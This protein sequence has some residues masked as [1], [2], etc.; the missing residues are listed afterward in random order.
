SNGA[1]LLPFWTQATARVHT[2]IARRSRPPRA[3]NDDSHPATVA[4]PAQVDAGRAGVKAT[5]ARP[6]RRGPSVATGS[7]A[8]A[9]RGR[10]P[11]RPAC[12]LAGPH[13]TAV[14][15]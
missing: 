9:R 12:R 6:W 11:G 10:L 8:R 1:L 2:R 3:R 4:W 7:R 5:V 15:A 14:P 13:R